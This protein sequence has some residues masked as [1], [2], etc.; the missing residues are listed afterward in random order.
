MTMPTASVRRGNV[1][2]QRAQGRPRR[3][4][5]SDSVDVRLVR[6]EVRFAACR[7][8]AGVA[9]MLPSRISMMRCACSATSALVRD[10]MIE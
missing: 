4:T 5:T 1:R 10:Q 6:R 8:R 2:A 9:T 3:P 7:R